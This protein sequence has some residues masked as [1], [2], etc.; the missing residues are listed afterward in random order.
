MGNL[1][2]KVHKL[3]IWPINSCCQAVLRTPNSLLN[4]ASRLRP[5]TADDPWIETEPATQEKHCLCERCTLKYRQK[6]Q[7]PFSPFRIKSISPND[8]NYREIIK[9]F[10]IHEG[11]E[12]K[13]LIESPEGKDIEITGCQMPPEGIS[14][15]MQF[16][17]RFPRGDKDANRYRESLYR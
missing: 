11:Q 14:G 6:N 7:E 10:D 5:S 12:T 13:S 4:I 9:G 16:E 8:E 2:L 17:N 3:Y 1:Q 15:L